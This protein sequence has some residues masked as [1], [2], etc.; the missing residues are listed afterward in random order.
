[1]SDFSK[2]LDH[3]D[4]QDIIEKLLAG[5]APKEVADWLKL[6]YDAKEQSH[7]R[8]SPRILKEF[9]D[10]NLDLHDIV[11]NDIDNIKQEKAISASL[12]NNKTYQQRIAE[13][14]GQEINLRGELESIITVIRTRIEQI[15]D[16]IQDDPQNVKPDFTLQ[17]WLDSMFTFCE[18]YDKIV[19]H[20]PDKVIQHNVTMQTVDQY[21][22]IFQDAIKSTLSEMDTEVA[23]LFMEKLNS[24]LSKLQ[25]PKDEV[26]SQSD[27]IKEVAMLKSY[28]IPD[29]GDSNG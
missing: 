12:R 5:V 10:K 9:I 11:R 1:M 4:K 13:A 18:R 7:L 29:T 20:A 25:A 17:K 21:T 27:R 22:V 16:M 14:A 2:L 24:K 3:P 6:R 19:N 28:I 23:F 26:L 8:L 15:F